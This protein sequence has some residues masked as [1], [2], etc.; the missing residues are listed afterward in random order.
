MSFS[1]IVCDANGDEQERCFR[2]GNERYLMRKGDGFRLLAELNNDS[3]D[4]F[5]SEE[6]SE[7]TIELRAV[8]AEVSAEGDRIH[9][10]RLIELAETTARH[11]GS[12]I[13]FTPFRR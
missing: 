10:G 12:T 7:L 6:A 9:L 2:D 5:S 8:Q 3:Y 13:T 11:P 1:V 4:V